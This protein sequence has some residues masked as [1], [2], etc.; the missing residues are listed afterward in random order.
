MEQ[1]PT[2]GI[3]PYPFN[4]V[5]H[6]KNKKF[7]ANEQKRH[8]EIVYPNLSTEDRIKLLKAD[9]C[10]I[11]GE[12]LHNKKADI[13]DDVLIGT[14]CNECWIMTKMVQSRTHLNQITDYLKCN[15]QLKEE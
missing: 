5:N 15:K 13:I 1:M 2:N 7:W 4:K 6:E 8:L 14:L 10:D 9:K 11:C 12:T 3:T